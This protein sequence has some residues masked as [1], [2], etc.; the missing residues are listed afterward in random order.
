M[1]CSQVLPAVH[2]LSLLSS[3]KRF[4]NVSCTCLCQSWRMGGVPRHPYLTTPHVHF[5]TQAHNHTNMERMKMQKCAP[6]KP[7]GA[8][9]SLL[10]RF[11][12]VYMFITWRLQPC[13]HATVCCENTCVMLAVGFS[14]RL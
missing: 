9:K 8:D 2:V 13:Y 14:H 10:G 4:I 1:V 5:L 12:Y 11:L 3:R 6:G 7:H